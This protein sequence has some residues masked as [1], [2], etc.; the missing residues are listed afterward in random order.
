MLISRQW[1]AS[2]L[3]PGRQPLPDDDALPSVV[4]SLGLE[5]EG[6][7]RYGA[8]L[9]AIVVGEVAGKRPHPSADTLG[10]VDVF[11]GG[12]TQT[13]VCGASN[14]PEVGGRI[15]LAPV[16]TRLPG[17]LTIAPRSIRGVESCGMI[18]SEAE[19]DLGPDADGTMVL[20]REWAAGERLVDRV[21]G[22]VDTVLELGVT[23]NRPDALGHVGVARDLAAKLGCSLAVA[24]LSPPV[25]APEPTLVTLSAPDRCGRYFGYALSGARVGPSPLWM[26]VRLHRLGL[27]PINNVVDITNF[28]LLEWGQP[29]HAFDRAR[30]AEGRVEVRLAAA[31][32][33]LT[34]L[35]GAALQL[36][37]DDLV[38]ADARR[39]Q[40]LAGV[41]G[42]KD[43]GVDEGST[44]LLL[45][46]A[47]FAPAAVRRTARRHQI[48]SDS[49][50]SRGVCA[51]ACRSW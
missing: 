6:V 20:P 29:L 48:S 15:A 34:T 40:A 12:S 44:T 17:G 45:E 24:P 50:Y 35:D 18:C 16:G 33:T 23:A 30:L 43:S 7:T 8:G 5:V 25:A 28:V 21:P 37:A 22:I 19:L 36:T 49:A 46:A 1:I 4:T 26:R 27:R 47:W 13:V 10:L 14:V 11:D 39:P 38:I 3:M 9:D 42:G 2:M 31:G 51:P 41:M 32:E